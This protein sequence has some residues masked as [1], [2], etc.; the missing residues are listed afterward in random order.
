ME[1]VKK[2]ERKKRENQFDFENFEYVDFSKDISKN[3]NEKS[4]RERK[5]IKLISPRFPQLEKGLSLK[6]S[7]DIID[8]VGEVI[9]KKY[10]YRLNGHLTSSYMLV[11]EITP[12]EFLNDETEATGS[13]ESQEEE[14][15]EKDYCDY[16]EDYRDCEVFSPFAE[17]GYGTISDTPSSRGNLSNYSHGD[18]DERVFSQS[19]LMP[20]ASP[21]SGVDSQES[22]VDPQDSECLNTSTTTTSTL[23]EESPNELS[24][25]STTSLSSMK[26][27]KTRESFETDAGYDSPGDSDD[28]NQTSQEISTIHEEPQSTT[29]STTSQ[30]AEKIVEKLQESSIVSPVSQSTPESSQKSSPNTHQSLRQRDMI[31]RSFEPF[32]VTEIPDIIPD[33]STP[34]DPVQ[35]K[36]KVSTKKRKS[37][38][39][40]VMKKKLKKQMENSGDKMKKKKLLSPD[41]ILCAS[42]KKEI[43]ELK[44]LLKERFKNRL[45]F[46]Y[47][48]VGTDDFL[49]FRP[50]LLKEDSIIVD[51]ALY[52]EKCQDETK[53]DLSPHESVELKDNRFSEDLEESCLDTEIEEPVDSIEESVD[54]RVCPPPEASC[55]YTPPHSPDYLDHHDYLDAMDDPGVEEFNRENQPSHQERVER[56][57][58]ELQN[59]FDIINE[60]TGETERWL[61]SIEVLR[62]AE[63]RPIFNVHDYE[64]RV[65][66]T[67]KN[68]DD[69]YL[70]F[71]EVVAREE[72]D[73]I[74][75]LFLASLH[76]VR[77]FFFSLFIFIHLMINTS[78]FI[79]I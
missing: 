64:N 25:T 43:K 66:D 78:C 4:N 54:D 68:A 36:P 58:K 32:P 13:S 45:N 30:E 35:L 77:L 48:A 50:R 19:P 49:G 39:E 52:P 21:D 55:S 79:F 57:M 24:E 34:C 29:E 3:I 44:R 62:A 15:T 56:R 18:D 14:I 17:S 8:V 70:S 53:E 63:R 20:D 69:N 7:L 38:V 22:G 75:R 65:I 42:M 11:D 72:P 74:A 59:E 31:K 46:S 12:E 41:E 71:E 40:N 16:S 5:K 27:S 10:D 67:L 37:T 73:D 28:V 26:N 33:S 9:G 60:R 2:K 76:L 51:G 47:D 6:F 1:K 61:R 23:N